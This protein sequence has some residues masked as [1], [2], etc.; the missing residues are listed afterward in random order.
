MI[1]LIAQR[2]KCLRNI[3][4]QKFQ[5]IILTPGLFGAYLGTAITETMTAIYNEMKWNEAT[6]GN[7]SEFYFYYFTKQELVAHLEKLFP[8]I[9]IQYV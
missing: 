1:A 6:L 3:D 8:D 9:E 4:L 5:I 2:K 7:W